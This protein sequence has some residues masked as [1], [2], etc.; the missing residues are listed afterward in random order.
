MRTL[1]VVVAVAVLC[2]A[3]VR[4]EDGRLDWPL[5]RPRPAV[6]RGFDAPSWQHRGHRGVDL[7]PGRPDSRYMR[8]PRAVDVRRGTWPG[9]RWCRSPTPGGLR[10]SYE[11][12]RPG[13]GRSAGR[14]GRGARRVGRRPFRRRRRVCTGV[15]CG[16]RRPAPTTS[17]R[18]RCWR[19]RRSGSSPCTVDRLPAS[20][21]VCT[22]TR[23]DLL[24]PSRG[25]SGS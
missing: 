14:R 18:W 22:P 2:A 20:V 9:G 11:P 21:R 23:R 13:A 15:R 6:T 12:V 24:A 16:A 17:I 10:T 4:A 25:V 5:R 7:R 1:T 3:P 19:R 8:P